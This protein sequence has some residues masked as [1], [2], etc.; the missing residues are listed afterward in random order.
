MGRG[1]LALEP[2]LGS[3]RS[4]P[5]SDRGE[6]R[7]PRMSITVRNLPLSTQPLG[8]VVDI[9]PSAGLRPVHLRELWI[10][11]ELL[12]FLVWRDIK[13]RYKQTVLGAVWAVL[14]PVL[15]MTVF[16]IFLGKF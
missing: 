7:S 5:L 14:Q 16:A 10:Y 15:T 8:H 11:R 1:A 6:E 4:R 3:G 9:E 13:V 12:Y 2:P